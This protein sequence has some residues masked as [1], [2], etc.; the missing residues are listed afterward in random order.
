MGVCKNWCGLHFTDGLFDRELQNRVRQTTKTSAI[1]RIDENVFDTVGEHLTPSQ[2]ES[3]GRGEPVSVV[4]EGSKHDWLLIS[5]GMGPTK[6][7][8]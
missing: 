4:S 1:D 5:V 8:R 7:Q 6:N 3:L 2:R